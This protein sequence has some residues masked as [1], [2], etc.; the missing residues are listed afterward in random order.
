M[1][2]MADR[3]RE[4]LLAPEEIARPDVAAT[5][6]AAV[7]VPLY[8][9]RGELHAVLTRRHAEL[10]RHGG[11]I[12]FPGGRQ[13]SDAEDLLDAALREAEEEIGLAREAVALV[14]GLTPVPTFVSGY[15]I[16]PF[17]ALIEPSRPW[18]PSEHEVEAVLECS[19]AELAASRRRQRIS[20]DGVSLT[21]DAYA[22]GDE[23]V[24]GATARIVGELLER[25]APL[26]SR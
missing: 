2:S 9:E 11:E 14:G 23:L 18:L 1:V 17:V 12:S 7:L 10:R 20:R 6:D 15:V 3:L 13:E 26:L 19:L 22:V 4:L 16:Y 24:W 21:A 8:L 5:R 25:V